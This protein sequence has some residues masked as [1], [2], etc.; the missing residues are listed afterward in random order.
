MKLLLFTAGLSVIA[1]GLL[2]SPGASAP[3]DADGIASQITLSGTGSSVF[4]PI[5]GEYQAFVTL[6]AKS[7]AFWPQLAT[8][9]TLHVVDATNGITLA[10][11]D[12]VTA[13]SGSVVVK[14]PAGS[15]VPAGESRL[16]YVYIELTD[17]GKYS[18]HSIAKNQLVGGS[19]YDQAD[20]VDG[21]VSQA[22]V[23]QSA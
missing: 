6:F 9:A 11:V 21:T 3:G 15:L 7:G 19:R 1:V 5:N 18:H 4:R 8:N 16:A 22:V 14:I 20:R 2:A 23:I 13:A 12:F 10:T 17:L